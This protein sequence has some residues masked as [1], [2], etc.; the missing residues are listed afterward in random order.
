VTPNE[1]RRFL[2]RIAKRLDAP[3][4]SQTIQLLA[5][6][7]A[8]LLLVLVFFL[9]IRFDRRGLPVVAQ[10]FVSALSGAAIMLVILNT[11]SS[12][13]WP[14]LSRFISR[15]DLRKRLQELGDA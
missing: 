8:W 14:V 6:L 9:L 1:E 7:G 13:V 12:K 5:R 2:R 15:E 11:Q 10:L 4:R 3:P